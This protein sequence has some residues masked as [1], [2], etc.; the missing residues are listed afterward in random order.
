MTSD[1]VRPPRG[2][3]RASARTRSIWLWQLSIAAVLVIIALAILALEPSLLAEPTTEAGAIAIIVLTG[4]TLVTPW[5]RLPRTVVALV[6]ISDVLAIGLLAYGG[7]L[8]LGFLWVFPVAWIASYYR[9]GWMIGALGLVG[10]IIVLDTLTHDPS[11]D[12]TL[13]FLVVLLS[14]T[15]ISITMFNSAL[16][17]HAF[18][19]LLRRQSER[20]ETTLE[21]VRAQERRVNQMLNGLD[22]A[23]AHIDREGRLVG[24]NDAYLSLYGID[25]REPSR[26]PTSIE[27]DSRGGTALRQ[28]DRPATRAARGEL[29]SDE[30]LWLFDAEGRWHIISASTRELDNGPSESPTTLLVIRDI[31]EAVEAESARRTLA[32]TVTHELANPLTAIVGYTDLLLEEDLPPRSRERLELIEAAG[33]RMERLIAEVLRQGGRD[34]RGD[35]PR[36]RIDART[37]LV[38]TVESFIPAAIAG[39]V[40][41]AL[42]PGPAVPI[43]ADAFRLRQVFDNLVSNA[44]KYTPRAGEVEVTLTAQGTDAVVTI[45][46]TGI[47]IAPQDLPLIFDDYFRAETARDAGL[48]GT[49]LGMGISR[50]IVEQH[51]GALEVASEPEAGTTVTVRMPLASARTEEDGHE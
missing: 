21:R 40:A 39:D 27:Y 51:G 8:R 32:T 35:E 19:R 30:R 42:Q 41:L 12:S 34:A 14:L 44:V 9:L 29:F 48:P 25:P 13:R 33:Q 43:V 3:V 28:H 16:R 36:R 15:F 23:V 31:T 7:D 6:P 11:V 24:V 26:P 49:G 18:T 45:R 5:H 17:S 20:L 37:L 1:A 4:A 2:T 38:A 10:A 50:S 46:D 47:G 22:S